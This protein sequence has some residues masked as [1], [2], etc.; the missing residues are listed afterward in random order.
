MAPV[1][2]NP[3]NI[4]SF[5]TE[6]AF[7]AWLKAHH[8]TQTELWLRIYKK[9]ADTPTVTYAEAVDVALCWGWIDGLKKTYDDASF[10]QRFT[11][12]KGKSIW[13]QKN[14]D[15]IDRLSKAGRMTEHGQRHVDA[16]KADGRWDAAYAPAS[17]MEIPADLLA[18]IEANPKA[19]ETFQSLN[20]QN[21]F[22][23]AFR[24]GNV[25]TA[26]TR[27]KKVENFVEMLARGETLYPNGAGKK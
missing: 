19:L 22:A 14:R 20:K 11:P 25:K 24:I 15:H 7:E 2:P 17:E 16:A 23:M 21:L 13:S 6:A 10:I 9:G 12:R 4:R 5:P 26:A 18:A 3:D 1:I 27:A 8:D